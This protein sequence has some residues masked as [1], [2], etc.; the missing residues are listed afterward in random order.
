LVR[1][2]DEVVVRYLPWLEGNA[3]LLNVALPL[4]GLA[5]IVA[6]GAAHNPPWLRF[7]GVIL[8]ALTPLFTWSAVR[9]WRRSFLHITPSALTSQSSAPKDELIV[10]SREHVESISP[11]VVPNG[12]GGEWL[13][14]E[15]AYTTAD[16]NA[17]QTLL[18]G[19]QL[20]VEPANLL[21]ALVA[22]REAADDDPEELLDR[23]EALL[24]GRSMAGA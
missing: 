16:S 20:T 19:L 10:L 21:N 22:W 18:L 11:K 3:Y 5:S 1:A 7:V 23:V 2:S 24:R 9:M 4:I 8:I 14:V 12:V 15:I 6:S 17:T 13:Q